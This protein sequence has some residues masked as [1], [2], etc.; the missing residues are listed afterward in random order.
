M[1]DIVDNKAQHRFE[2]T[3][4]GRT[5]QAF[6]ETSAQSWAEKN[7]EGLLAGEQVTLDAAAGDKAGPI[8]LAM[9]VSA[10]APDA[11]ISVF[12]VSTSCHVKMPREVLMAQTLTS[13]AMLPIQLNL[14][15]SNWAP[16][17][18]PTNG[19]NTM[20]RAVAASTAS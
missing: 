9:A 15:A 2:L 20:P 8:T 19:S 4:E 10:P 17:R 14:G 16:S 11:P 18:C 12:L 5:P 7:L 6:V 3:V 1:S 13:L